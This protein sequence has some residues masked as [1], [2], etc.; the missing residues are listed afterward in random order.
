MTRNPHDH[1]HGQ[2]PRS[3]GRQNKI[4]VTTH[5]Y[6][7]GYSN[8]QVLKSVI[9]VQTD[10]WFRT[11]RKRGDFST[12][13]TP[14]G[15]LLVLTES[16]LRL[17]EYHAERLL[18]YVELDGAKINLSQV[19]HNLFAQSVTLRAMRGGSLAAYQTER[20]IMLGDA[21]GI[22]RP[23][24]VWISK[25][26]L[27]IAVEIEL[28]SKWAR[29]FDDFVAGVVAALDESSGVAAYDRFVVIT[30]SKALLT[31]YQESMSAGQPLH[32]WRKDGGGKWSIAKKTKIPAWIGERVSFR[33]LEAA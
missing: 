18:P 32:V 14:D 16:T 30:D 11:A 17:A 26:G 15:D 5:I 12:V 20:E 10:T 9:G 8:V 22:K 7:F 24:V 28:T 2:A 1:L 33:L 3:R 29:H 21:R 25:T 4:D 13:K 31:R 19:R 6:R 27:R 23:D